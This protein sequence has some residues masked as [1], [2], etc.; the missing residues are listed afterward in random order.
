MARKTGVDARHGRPGH[1]EAR[2]SLAASLAKG[3]CTPK[4]LQD[5][6]LKI[7]GE[8]LP[9]WQFGFS[10]FMAFLESLPD[11]VRISGPRHACM[12]YGQ[13]NESTKH[14]ARMVQS[15][16]LQSKGRG[17][18]RPNATVTKTKQTEPAVPMD[19][20]VNLARLFLAFP[21]G[22]AVSD[23]VEAYGRRFGR[24]PEFSRWGYSSIEHLL[25]SLPH[26]TCLKPDG[27]GGECVALPVAKSPTAVAALAV[28]GGVVAS[29]SSS[30]SR[31]PAAERWRNKEENWEDE[32]EDDWVVSSDALD[33]DKQAPA[34]KTTNGELHCCN[35]VWGRFSCFFCCQR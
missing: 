5:D 25:R 8:P 31:Q 32:E 17:R 11:V 2:T 30:L 18:P 12:L 16:R 21:D 1:G 34:D 10:S 28:K 27:P 29:S 9:Y 13:A 19:F 22:V 7:I 33:S 3:G 6:Y 15:Q 35:Y 20:E 14:I 26:I 24:Y 4:Q 23:F